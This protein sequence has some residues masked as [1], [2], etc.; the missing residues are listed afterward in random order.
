MRRVLTLLGLLVA[1]G[2]CAG[3]TDP[4]KRPDTYVATGVNDDNL[5]AMIVNPVDLQHG[6]GAP[7]TT[8]LNAAAAVARLRNDNVHQLPSSNLSD[9]GSGAGAGGQASGGTTGATG[10]TQ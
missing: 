3:L 6:V 8:G 1:L 7:D 4:F 10:G 2:G 9:I 5:R